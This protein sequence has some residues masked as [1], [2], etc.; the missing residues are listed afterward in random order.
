MSKLSY[1]WLVYLH[2]RKWHSHFPNKFIGT[3]IIIL[4]RFSTRFLKAESCLS[5]SSTPLGSIF[6]YHLWKSKYIIVFQK[7]LVKNEL[8][9]LKYYSTF[10]WG[11]FFPSKFILKFLV[12][13]LKRYPIVFF[14]L[15]RI[16]FVV[17]DILKI[18]RH[19]VSLILLFI[20]IDFIFAK[21]I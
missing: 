18:L 12:C 1:F 20:T 8:Q 3:K 10:F 17:V 2:K 14:T 21:C 7:L 16:V 6:L 9:S 4:Q 15:I 19:L 11:D 13:P 5:H